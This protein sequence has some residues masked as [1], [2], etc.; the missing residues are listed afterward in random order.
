MMIRI[1]VLQCLL[2]IVFVVEGINKRFAVSNVSNDQNFELI[3]VDRL[4]D[5]NFYV[6]SIHHNWVLEEEQ[7]PVN[8]FIDALKNKRKKCYTLDVGMNDG[9]YTMLF[10]AHGCHVLSFELQAKCIEFAR[11]ALREN[12]FDH[13]VTVLN[14]PVYNEN[15]YLLNIGMPTH[16]K[17]LGGFDI[18]GNLN[19]RMN[20]KSTPREYATVAL[21]TIVPP[22]GFIDAL[23]IDVEGHDTEVLM[24][25][26]RLFRD[27]QIGVAVIEINSSLGLWTT[28]KNTSISVLKDI[29][30][31]NYTVRP[32]TCA[33]GSPNLFRELHTFEDLYHQLF[34]SGDCI[35]FEFRLRL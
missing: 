12:K 24:G 29:M 4:T 33:K 10:A 28:E 2:S 17:C 14:Q 20:A 21:D 31:Y 13:L 1:V 35:D 18:S 25:A 19:R 16:G 26:R 8:V 9:F 30:S 5:L 6:G 34:T 3:L 23:K 32:V 11:A 7:G 27:H 22:N 15:G